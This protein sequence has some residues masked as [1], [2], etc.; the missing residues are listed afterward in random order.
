MCERLE[1]VILT[2]RQH[3]W[4]F[5]RIMTLQLYTINCPF[6]YL[7]NRDITIHVLLFKDRFEAPR[8]SLVYDKQGDLLACHVSN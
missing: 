6:I 7:M 2:Q 8:A 4:V 3:R 5:D 1:G